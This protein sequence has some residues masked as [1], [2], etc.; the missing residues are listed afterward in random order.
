MTD[1][2]AET[3]HME[4]ENDVGSFKNQTESEIIPDSLKHM[5]S[6]EIDALMK[7]TTRRMDLRILPMLVL[8]YILN[9]LDRNNIASARLNTLEE[10]LGL[11][12]TQ[13]QT[14]VSILFVTYI[15]F[16]IPANMIFNKVARPSIFMSILMTVW[17][18]ISACTGAIRKEHGFVGLLVIRLI[19]GAVE[20]A[21]FPCALFF[22][23][24]WYD[25]KELALRTTILYSGSLLSGAFSG[26]IAAGILNNMDG[27]GGLSGWRYLFIIE[28]AITVAV[29]PMA[30]FILPDMPHNTKWLTQ[31]ERDVIM[32]KMKRGVGQ[33]DLDQATT[34][35]NYRQ[36]LWSTCKDPKMWSITGTLSFLVAACGVTNFFPSVVKTLGFS[37][38]ITLVLTAPPYLLAVVSTFLWA[39]HADKTGERF[40]H[41]TLPLVISLISFIIS[42]ATLNTGARYFAMCIMIPSLYCS[43]TII[44]TH[45][46]NSIPRPP[47]RR[48]CAIAIMNCL[49]NSTSIWNS[50]LYPETN[51]PRYLTAFVC[52]CVFIGLAV[53]AA[54]FTR[55]RLMQL[56]KRIASGTMNWEKEFGKGFDS[57]KISEDFRFLY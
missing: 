24:K 19:I 31:E 47:L 8:I 32:L 41:T 30:Y 22:L 53:C 56:N 20:S 43:F 12:G 25:K 2:K 29:V 27:K 44:L 1:F 37:S 16:Q 10:D 9:Y 18:A 42:A 36:I 34:E 49:S 6:E 3:I 57:S 33:D 45:M 48:A 21:F 23:S 52:N 51:A 35:L 15:T 13:Y 50:Y 39:R 54:V 46:S 7:K 4:E 11:V 28:G 40:Y 26:L 38:V 14:C 55:F 5:S 17:G